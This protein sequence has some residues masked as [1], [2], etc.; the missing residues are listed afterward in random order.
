MLQE[1]TEEGHSVHAFPCTYINED[2]KSATARAHQM[3]SRSKEKLQSPENV[4]LFD[5]KNTA[6]LSAASGLRWCLR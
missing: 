6:N 3:K 1:L 5:Y 4:L 2:M